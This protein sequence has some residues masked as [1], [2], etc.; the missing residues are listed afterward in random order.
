MTSSTAPTTDEEQRLVVTRTLDAAPD[1]VF[2]LLTDPAQHHRL[3]PTDWVGEALDP[4]QGP[5]TAEGQVFGI[6]MFHVN[7]GGEYHMHNRV[8]AYVPQRTLAWEPGQFDA[9]GELGTG[10]WT[11][12]YDLE[13][14][15]DGTRVQITYDWSGVPDALREQFGIPPFGPDYLERS[16]ASLAEAL[17]EDA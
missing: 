7:A 9:S 8:I 14:A 6:R 11:W 12:R 1:A 15:A 10:G 13:P 4:Q 2:A 5:I 17:G 16:L 3:E